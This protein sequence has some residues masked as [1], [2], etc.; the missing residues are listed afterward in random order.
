MSTFD[1][2]IKASARRGSSIGVQSN[3]LEQ[4]ST[5]DAQ[6]LKVENLSDARPISDIECKEIINKLKLLK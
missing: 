5:I 3:P 2:R 1:Q 6:S 4:G